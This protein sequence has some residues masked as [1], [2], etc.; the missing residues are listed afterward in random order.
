MKYQLKP[1]HWENDSCLSP[2]HRYTIRYDEREYAYAVVYYNK[3]K[4]S[5]NIAYFNSKE[6]AKEWVENI[7]IPAKLRYYFNEIKE[8]I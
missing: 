4:G 8:E 3:D 7:H 6:Q 1:I 5:T 2:T